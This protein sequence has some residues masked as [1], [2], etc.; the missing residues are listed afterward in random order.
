MVAGVAV[1]VDVDV[2]AADTDTATGV[3][4]LGA[5]TTGVD[6]GD[7]DVVEVD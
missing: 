3:T 1:G 6:V 5:V 7:D 4:S 2:S